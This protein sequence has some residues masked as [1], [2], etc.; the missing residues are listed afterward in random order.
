MTK[1]SAEIIE[2]LNMGQ[3]V[4]VDSVTPPNTLVEIAK[5]V[6]QGQQITIRKASILRKTQI[7]DILR[8]AQKG[9]ITFDFMD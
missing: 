5:F 6:G 1:N 4:V 7:D 9:T 2:I 3:N 8:Y